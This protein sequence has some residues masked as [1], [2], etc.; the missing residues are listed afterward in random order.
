M[1]SF[2][3]PSILIYTLP[4]VFFISIAIMLSSLS[5]DNE[6]LVMFALGYK[7]KKLTFFFFIL[8]L[9]TSLLLLINSLILF[10]ISKQAYKS[11]I[12]SKKVEAKINIKPNEFGQKFGDWM[13]FINSVD[14][15]QK[16]QDIVMFENSN[17][18]KFIY[19]KEAVIKNNDGILSLDLLNGQ[20]YMLEDRENMKSIS[21]E[22][23]QILFDIDFK[24]LSF[25]TVSEYWAKASYDKNI[26]NKLIFMLLLSLLPLAIFL[27]AI[28][29]GVVNYRYESRNIYM[30]LFGM[31]LFYY[32]TM[33]A[34]RSSNPYYLALL[35]PIG[36]FIFSY[37]I[38]TKLIKNKY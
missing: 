4:E 13:V 11:F 28:A 20:A 12:S 34:I 31:I 8:A 38:Y 33:F 25:D 36:V 9:I 16:Y 24:D 22:K 26:R 3:I 19:S 5:K 23:L 18:E 21:Y 35:L 10:P 15:H 17:K 27:F 32:A 14:K 2:L 37:F 7:P 29:I 1:Y 30:H 6:L